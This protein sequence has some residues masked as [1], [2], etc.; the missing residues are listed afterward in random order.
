MKIQY[1]DK[2]FSLKSIN[3]I[4]TAN[5]IIREYQADGFDLTLRQL[6]Y[7]MVARDLIPNT[8]KEYKRI[9]SI[10]NDARMAG[11]V[12]W[13]AIVDRTR[14]LRR[15]S[16]WS[17]PASILESAAASYLQDK[18]NGQPYRVEVWIEKDAL[19]GVIADVCEKWDAPYFSCRGYN[20]QSNMWSAGHNRFR[21]NRR[22]KKVV[23]H[24]GDHDPS[25]IDMTRD[26]DDR[27]AIFA[28]GAEV[29]DVRRI[30]LT[31]DQVDLY[32]PPPNPAKVTDSRANGYIDRFGRNSWELDALEP[33]VI[34]DLIESSIKEL[35]DK[36][37]WDDVE[38]EIA[39]H[40]ATLNKIA[41][42]YNSIKEYIDDGG[43]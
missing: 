38:A 41:E 3:L 23:L 26:I 5:K 19:V 6:Y 29:V 8:Q 2:K 27:L 15:N 10:L 12:D 13:Y 32:G 37:P 22:Q 24:L 7:Q 20:S 36:G 4:D 14:T 40:R 9:G 21:E 39:D 28:E 33:R 43:F 25:G 16:H 17:H 11:L 1:I 35:I 34:V 18:W 42:N 30:A 31:M